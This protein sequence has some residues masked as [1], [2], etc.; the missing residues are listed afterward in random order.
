MP[1]PVSN[2]ATPFLWESIGR[3]W[4][5][6]PSGA[7]SG[8]YRLFHG[9]L[10]ARAPPGRQSLPG[11]TVIGSV[12]TVVCNCSAGIPSLSLKGDVAQRRRPPQ[13]AGYKYTPFFTSCITVVIASL[14]SYH[15]TFALYCATVLFATAAA[16]TAH[17]CITSTRA[18]QQFMTRPS[19]PIF[20]AQQNVVL[21]EDA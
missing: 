16:H 19:A 11:H 17:P 5:K 9:A 12:R 18:P 8:C 20:A 10:D 21:G 13:W 6:V 15:C 1:V 2:C 7:W 14:W 4:S 3:E